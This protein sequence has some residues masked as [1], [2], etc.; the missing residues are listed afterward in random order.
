[1]PGSISRSRLIGLTIAA[2]FT[3][4]TRI[5]ANSES[6]RA[7]GLVRIASSMPILPTSCRSAE[8]STVCSSPPEM[9]Q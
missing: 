6:V 8:I 3:V 2:P 1:M 5:W 4:C 9:P 7:S